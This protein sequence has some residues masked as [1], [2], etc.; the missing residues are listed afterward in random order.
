MQLL[1]PDG[2]IAAVWGSPNPGPTILPNPVAVAFDAAG[3]GYVL[4]QPPQPAS[5]SS[6]ARP[7]THSRRSAAGLAAPAQLL[8]PAALAIDGAGTISVADA[9]ND[10]IARFAADGTYLGSFP[11]DARR[12]A[13]R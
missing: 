1:N 9:G 10:R 3:N 4:D 7:A 8:S 6:T 13:S 11:T 5:S 12:A 2:T